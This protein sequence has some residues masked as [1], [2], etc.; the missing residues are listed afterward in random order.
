MLKQACPS[1]DTS[2]ILI[3][4]SVIQS[5]G[6]L[7]TK[8]S[9]LQCSW[10]LA[11]TAVG[12]LVATGFVLTE[13]HQFGSALSNYMAVS[14]YQSQKDYGLNISDTQL[15]DEIQTEVGATH[16]Y[17]FTHQPEYKSSYGLLGF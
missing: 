9:S 16:M 1:K 13:Q 2:N 4:A 14:M 6:K 12:E 5:N 15:W 10:L 8:Y 7:F 11:L 17:E 3:R